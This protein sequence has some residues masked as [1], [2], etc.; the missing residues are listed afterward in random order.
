MSIFEEL[1][2]G[3]LEQ[4]REHRVF[5]VVTAIVRSMREDRT[6]ELQYLSMGDN[7]PS[8]PARMMMPM[9]GAERGIHFMPEPGDEV[10]VAFE[11]GDMNQ[12]II[13]GAVWNQNDST[14]PQVSGPPDNNV[15]AI[16][17]RSGHQLIFDDTTGAEKVT[18]QTSRG[19]TI[20]L[21][22]T[23]PG[24]V[25]LSSLAG[26]SIEFD[27]ATATLRLKAAA[28]LDLS[29]QVLTISAT[30]FSLSAPG[31]VVLTTTGSAPTSTF[32]I[33]GKPFG[34]HVHT[35]PVVPPAGT[36]GPVAP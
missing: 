28:I 29:A 19:H 10:V 25:T 27:D 23:P 4:A 31:G 26:S 30:S 9:A 24:K 11:A 14:P 17:S 16:V 13:L 1:L 5:G 34:L 12:P 21:D 8:A 32:V 6:F 20:V 35:P 15:R 3:K 7:Q 36:T 22:D 33:D 18:I 2:G